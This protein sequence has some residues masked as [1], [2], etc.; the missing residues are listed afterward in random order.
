VRDA[1]ELA[2]LPPD[3]RAEW[4]K[5]WNDLAPPASPKPGYEIAPPPRP[6]K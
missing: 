5:F 4:E 3:E 6:G 1:K 2:K